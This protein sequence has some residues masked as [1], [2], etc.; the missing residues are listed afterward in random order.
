MLSFLVNDIV[1]CKK[2][3]ELFIAALGYRIFGGQ[4]IRLTPF[5]SSGIGNPVKLNMPHPPW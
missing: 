5:F 4:N 2:E 1:C 3:G